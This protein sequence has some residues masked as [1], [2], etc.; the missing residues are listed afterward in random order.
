MTIET[1]IA[2]AVGSVSGAVLSLIFIPP[3]SV[4]EFARR[5]SASL[6]GGM[7]GGQYVHDFR[8]WPEGFDYYVLASALAGFVTWWGLGAIKLVAEK[9]KG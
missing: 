3:R 1:L 2:K 4:G 7:V 9:W 5:G 8:T 6:I